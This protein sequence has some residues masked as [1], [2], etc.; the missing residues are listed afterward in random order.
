VQHIEFF[1]ADHFNR[2]YH[3]VKPPPE[4][5]QFVDFFW[6]TNFDTLWKKYPAGF[7]DVL[8]PNIGY[9]YLINLG[10]PYTMQVGERKFE[11]KTHGFLPRRQAIECFHRPGNC[12]FGIK[13]R[14]SP[15][16]YG[17]KV[18]FAEYREYIFPLSY[19]MEQQV[20]QQIKT[21]ATFSKRV[22]LVCRYFQQMIAVKIGDPPAVQA[23]T[24]VLWYCEANNDFSKSV[25][26]FAAELGISS[27]TLQR[28]FE[29]CTSTNCKTAIQ[30]LR[31]RKATEHLAFSPGDFDYT[32]YGY[33]DYS[34]FCKHLKQFLQ[35]PEMEMVQLHLALL[36]GLPKGLQP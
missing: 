7:S 23:V 24:A 20:I 29:T 8:F 31:I 17:S 35:K 27:R 10:T 25:E 19:L 16:V 13:F 22:K 6:Q 15:V 28:Y 21:T 2:Y 1:H 26:S 12:L 30:I 36:K 14:I 32:R 34:H 11:M 9:T 3:R 33:Y 18:N 5:A 4:L